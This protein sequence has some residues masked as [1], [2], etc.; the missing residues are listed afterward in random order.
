MTK[1]PP[2]VAMSIPL[3]GNITTKNIAQPFNRSIANY[4]AIQTN[5]EYNDSS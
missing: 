5:W 1:S 4:K 3:L 2:L